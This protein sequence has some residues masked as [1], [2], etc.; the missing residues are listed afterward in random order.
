[1]LSIFTQSLKNWFADDPFTQSAAAAY[2]A[3]FSFPGLI[4]ILLS[5]AA[6]A[7]DEHQVE[8]LLTSHMIEI[9]GT[10]ATNTLN[11]IV[12]ETHHND[13][14]KL[15][16]IAGIV[17]LSFGA[18][19][20]FAHLQKSLNKI[21][22]VEVKKSAGVMI[23]IRT[24]LI[25]FGIVLILGL[26]LLI[27]LLLTA[28]ISLLSNWITGQ[29]SATFTTFISIL[30]F[31]TTFSIIIL[32]F[33]LIYKILPD[34]NIEWRSAFMGGIVA[35]LLFEIGEY[36]LNY[37]FNIAK[38]QT[39]FGAAGSLVLLMLWVSYSCMILFVG[40]EFCRVYEQVK[41]NRKVIP[42]KI[43]KKRPVSKG[44]G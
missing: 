28:L 40:A 1:V 41:F 44:H 30:S 10:D 29:F 12:Q 7:F 39:T 24:R 14:D 19:G 22:Q 34:A 26:L 27:S 32:L 9:L 25:S 3:I 43:A 36:S 4:F 17:T 8:T 38:P 37:Y 5:V 6:L 20:L 13:R 33:T 35:T 23:F 18:T 21:F 16:L 11:K 42:N 2:Y 31:T 15:A